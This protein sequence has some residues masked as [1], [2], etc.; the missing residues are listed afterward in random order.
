MNYLP[1]EKYTKAWIFRHKD[2]PVPAE[3]MKEIR[4]L[5]EKRAEQI[6]AEHISR[7]CFHPEH[8][9][10]DD[11]VGQGKYWS[12]KDCWQSAWDSS[13]EA[14]PPLMAASLSTWDDNITV[15]FCYQSDHILETKWG[16][17]RRHWKNFLFF[18]NGPIL[19]GRKRQ[20]VVQFF[21]NGS[22]RIGHRP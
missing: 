13:S 22:Y 18:D 9:S 14:L 21:D 4:P 17:F 7:G 8:F 11:W 5:A 10:E 3:D 16:V 20:E 12:E 2:L 6:W 19:L 1:I 15:Y